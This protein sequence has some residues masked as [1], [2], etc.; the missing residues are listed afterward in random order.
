MN[1]NEERRNIPIEI[2]EN[3]DHI[4]N[5]NV[6]PMDG[7][8]TFVN[9]L[10]YDDPIELTPLLFVDVNLGSDDSKRI[11]VYEGDTPK[12]LAQKFAIQNGKQRAHCIGLDE[13]SQVKLEELLND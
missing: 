5:I 2:S 9:S 11:V 12:K 4:H 13:G 3:D 8:S 10:D 7:K 6:S 1:S